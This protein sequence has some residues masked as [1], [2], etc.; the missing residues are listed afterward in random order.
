VKSKGHIPVERSLSSSERTL[1]QWLLMHGSS[2]ASKY[3]SQI[4]GLRIVSGCGCPTVDFALQSGRKVGGSDIVAEAGGKSPEGISVGVI[5]HV[6]DDEV[7]ELEVYSPR[8]W[9]FP[10]LCRPPIHLRPFLCDGGSPHNPDQ[11]SI[12]CKECNRLFA[13]TIQEPQPQPKDPSSVEGNKALSFHF[14]FGDSSSH[15]ARYVPCQSFMQWHLSFGITQ[16]KVPLVYPVCP[17]GSTS[18]TLGV[19][20]IVK[21]GVE[22][23][24]R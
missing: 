14:P 22:N 13:T 8:G 7:S 12:S 5:L 1:L 10:S 19:A 16:W 11:E 18:A 4:D 9:T 3:M 2:V 17:D 21:P 20:F 6:R 15:T 24:S 23:I